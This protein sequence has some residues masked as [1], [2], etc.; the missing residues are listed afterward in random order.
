MA[1]RICPNLDRPYSENLLKYNF[2]FFHQVLE[3]IDE[4]G[5]LTMASLYLGLSVVYY[6]P[7]KKGP[8]NIKYTIQS[9]T[10]HRHCRS[11]DRVI[12]VRCLCLLVSFLL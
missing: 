4:V 1:F 11:S 7:K 8:Q 5:K 6:H 10:R 9:F 2:L 12:A 3:N